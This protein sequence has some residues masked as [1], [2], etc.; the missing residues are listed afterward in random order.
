MYSSLKKTFCIETETCRKHRLD[1]G[2]FKSRSLGLEIGHDRGSSLNKSTYMYKKGI[3]L[4]VLL[5]K[6]IGQKNCN[7][8]ESVSFFR[9]GKFKFVPIMISGDRL[10]LQVG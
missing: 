5:K 7:L 10:W 1:S 9:K 3:I 2:M 6:S 4:K 8:R